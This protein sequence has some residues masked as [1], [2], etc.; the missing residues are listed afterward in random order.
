MSRLSLSSVSLPFSTYNDMIIA[1]H[2]SHGSDVDIH[3]QYQ[4][5]YCW[6]SCHEYDSAFGSLCP[7]PCNLLVCR[8]F[9][10]LSYDRYRY[11]AA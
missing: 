3:D 2:P 4:L 5:V 9:V 1:R 6:D 7:R 8:S 11:A 10:L